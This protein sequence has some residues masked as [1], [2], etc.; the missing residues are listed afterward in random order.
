MDVQART[1]PCAIQVVH[2]T[3]SDRR[4]RAEAPPSRR[5]R[6]RRRTT[7]SGAG[8]APSHSRAALPA[9]PTPSRSFAE[10]AHAHAPPRGE[11]KSSR[12]ARRADLGR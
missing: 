7:W 4:A 6:S 2:H 11:V 10:P 1:R 8:A 3:G 9:R 12:P 5:A